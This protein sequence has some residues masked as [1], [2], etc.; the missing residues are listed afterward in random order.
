MTLGTSIKL[1]TGA[2]IHAV[3]IGRAVTIPKNDVVLILVKNGVETNLGTFSSIPEACLFAATGVIRRDRAVSAA[4]VMNLPST[5][6]PRAFGLS[7]MQAKT[8]LSTGSLR[9]CRGND[10]CELTIRKT[11]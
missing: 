8:L 10:E 7:G 11:K 2:R 4:D 1:S 3:N 5:A 6:A 9:Y